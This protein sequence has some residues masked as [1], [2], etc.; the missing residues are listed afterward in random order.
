MQQLVSLGN[1]SLMM[2]EKQQNRLLVLQIQ[3]LLIFYLLDLLE[4]QVEVVLNMVFP[5]RI[6]LLILQDILQEQLQ[7]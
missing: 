5:D 4:L 2:L 7:I 3:L 1:L 6:L